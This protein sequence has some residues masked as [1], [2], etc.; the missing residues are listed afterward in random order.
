MYSQNYLISRLRAT[1]VGFENTPFLDNI[2]TGEIVSYGQFFSNAER[3]AAA[4]VQIGVK[5]GDRIAVQTPKTQTMLELYIATVMVGAV[6]LPLNPAY[7]VNEVQ[8]FL[9]DATPSLLVCTSDDLEEL[10][11]IADQ[12]KVANILTLN[13][14]ESGTLIDLR[15]QQNPGFVPVARARDDLAAILYTSGTTGRSKGAMLTHGALHQML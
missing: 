9:G 10:K 4:L 13:A 3:L 2:E 12:C 7:T 8:Y 11:T 15:N 6:F 1:S 5:P 14:D